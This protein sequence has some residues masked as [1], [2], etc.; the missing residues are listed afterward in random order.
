MF[1]FKNLILSFF[2]LPKYKTMTITEQ[3]RLSNKHQQLYDEYIECLETYKPNIIR[4][5]INKKIKFHDMK[6]DVNKVLDYINDRFIYTSDL[7]KDDWKI[8]K[9]NEISNTFKNDCDGYAGLFKA[10]MYELG[11]PKE[12]ISLTTCYVNK[13]N[14]TGYHM[15]AIIHCNDGDFLI[16]SRFIPFIQYW[17]DVDYYWDYTEISDN[18]FK[19]IINE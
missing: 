14:K 16:D 4:F 1:N 5:N 12:W 9:K 10:K 2:G 7:N 19:R 17:Y 3:H 6:R 18:N 13:E 11:Y 8:P 15:V